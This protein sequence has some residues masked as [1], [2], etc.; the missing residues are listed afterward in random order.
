MVLR[1]RAERRSR[2]V[3]MVVAGAVS[4]A[5]E[6]VDRFLALHQRIDDTRHIRVTF[7]A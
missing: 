2:P 4:R 1:E 6:S 7:S 5:P 3:G